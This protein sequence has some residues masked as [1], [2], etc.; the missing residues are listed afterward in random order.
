L[1]GFCRIC[2]TGLEGV[3]DTGTGA[4]AGGIGIADSSVEMRVIFIFF[5][6]SRPASEFNFLFVPFIVV[7][8]EGPGRVVMCGTVCDYTSKYKDTPVKKLK[9]TFLSSRSPPSGLLSRPP[10]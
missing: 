6:G 7:H 1:F 3:A 8:Q 2:S 10:F 5:A 4:G 9:S